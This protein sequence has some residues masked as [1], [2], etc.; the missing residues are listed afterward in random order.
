MDYMKWKPGVLVQIGVLCLT[1][2][3]EDKTATGLT[4]YTNNFDDQYALYDLYR[5]VPIYSGDNIMVDSGQLRIDVGSFASAFVQANTALFGGPRRYSSILENNPGTV[6]WAFNV[7]NQDAQYNNGFELVLSSEPGASLYGGYFYEFS[8]GGY[9]GNQ[10]LFSGN[11]QAL[12]SIPSSDGLGTL[13]SKG[14]FRITYEPST[15]LWSIFGVVGSDY[16]DPMTVTNLLGSVVDSSC[17]SVPL[18]YM[19]FKGD[20]PGQDYFDNVSVSVV[21]EPSA[22]RLGVLTGAI[23]TCSRLRRSRRY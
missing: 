16:V 21:P 17:T 23:A 18:R 13:P 11:G 4:V 22:A 15:D 12:I 3:L 19:T 8:G 1:I 10:M 20:Y 2:F 14:S 9:F 6:T 7:S 5:I